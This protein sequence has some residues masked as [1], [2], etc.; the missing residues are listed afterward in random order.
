MKN[1]LIL[2]REISILEAN[3][4][5]DPKIET[6]K[7]ELTEAL[8]KISQVDGID[9]VILRMRYIDG[10]TTEQIADAV[11]YSQRTIK[12]KLSHMSP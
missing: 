2:K 7:A 3:Y 9:G 8:D 5:D 10:K 6:L 4:P 11:G 1:I 12:R